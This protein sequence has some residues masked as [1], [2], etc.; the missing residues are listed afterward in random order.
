MQIDDLIKEYFKNYYVIIYD[1]SQ[2]A[3]ILCDEF[4][5]PANNSLSNGEIINIGSINRNSIILFWDK[6]NEV[7]GVEY[8]HKENKGKIQ[9]MFKEVISSEKTK[10]FFKLLINENIPVCFSIS[11][12][13]EEFPT[14]G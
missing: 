11:E 3:I 4:D 10:T 6:I 14:L 9:S 2:L 12:I 8:F 1:P 7:T 13:I 5:G